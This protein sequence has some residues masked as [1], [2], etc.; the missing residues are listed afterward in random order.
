MVSNKNIRRNIFTIIFLCSFDTSIIAKGGSLG[1]LLELL[2]LG[3]KLILGKPSNE[4]HVGEVIYPP[5]PIC[6]KI[7]ANTQ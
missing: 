5:T 3:Q 2:V 4:P 7:H 6:L 1:Y